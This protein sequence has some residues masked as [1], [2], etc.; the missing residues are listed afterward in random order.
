MIY[1][2]KEML[3]R[4]LP[5]TSPSALVPNSRRFCIEPKTKRGSRK[6]HE[7]F[8]K[9]GQITNLEL[10]PTDSKR[11]TRKQNQQIHVANEQTAQQIANLISR[12]HK[13]DVPFVEL[14]P[15]PCI[16]SKA[17]LGQLDM[18]TLVLIQ[19]DKEFAPIQQVF[20]SAVNLNLSF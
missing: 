16:L 20:L 6:I 10:F 13:K 1:Q 9:S 11:V 12:F 19:M 4:L 3:K 17:L 18:E 2:T 14:S 5:F 15:G 8:E 7:H